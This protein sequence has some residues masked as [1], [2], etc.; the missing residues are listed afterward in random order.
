[1]KV[2]G[3]LKGLK[4][5]HEMWPDLPGRPDILLRDGAV[6]VFVHGCFWHGCKDHF[7]VPKT[8]STFWSEKIIRN[9]ERHKKSEQA[10]W[11]LGYR[12]FVMWEHD[13]K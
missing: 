5:K 6:C 2:H 8:N 3:L 12:T 11:A 7:R 4:V 13:I 9:S 10:L 1:M